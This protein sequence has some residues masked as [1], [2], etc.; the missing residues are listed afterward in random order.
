MDRFE[1]YINNQ[2]TYVINESYINYVE[3]KEKYTEKEIN[4]ISNVI[5]M[6]STNY[7]DY[8]KDLWLNKFKDEKVILEKIKEINQ[9][10]DKTQ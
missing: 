1:I 9:C 5:A 6:T 2:L 10:S 4:C 3:V 7:W 8:G